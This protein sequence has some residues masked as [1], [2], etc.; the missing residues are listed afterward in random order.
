M[1]RWCGASSTSSACPWRWCRRA[2]RG[3]VEQS[4]DVPHLAAGAG[5][6]FAVEVE[7]GFRVGEDVGPA[8]CFRADEVAHLD[9]RGGEVGRAQ[10]QAAN[11]PDVIFELRG[12][13]AL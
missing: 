7:M 3:S 5:L 8:A 4:G 9:A 10:R 6:A 13:R 12:A 1:R 11:R 2:D